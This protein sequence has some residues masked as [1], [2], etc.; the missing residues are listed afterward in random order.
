M[1]LKILGLVILHLSLLIVPEIGE[2][3]QINGTVRSKSSTIYFEDFGFES[4]H[5]NGEIESNFTGSKYTFLL[6]NGDQELKG[7]I[8]DKLSK[9][10]VNLSYKNKNIEGQIKRNP[11]HT[12]DHWDVQFFGQKLSGTVGHNMANTKDTYDLIYGDKPIV[13]KIYLKLNSLVYDLQFGQKNI[14][15]TMAYNVSTVKHTYNLI[16]EDLTEDEFMVLVFIESIKLMNEHID[17]ID[18]FQEI[19]S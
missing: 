13:G 2:A 9:F 8:S 12:A 17:E 19:N 6:K 18:D 3:Q 14:S 10:G 1:R 7:E 5:F 4:F 11:N 16:A 15:G